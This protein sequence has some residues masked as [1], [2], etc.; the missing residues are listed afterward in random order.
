VLAVRDRGPGIP[1]EHL[2]RLFERFQHPAGEPVAPRG[3]GLGLAIAKSIAQMHHGT[4]S[5]KNREG[6]G[7]EFVIDLPLA[8]S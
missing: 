5:A 6:G 8:V 7:A 2:P 1:P 4:I 3:A